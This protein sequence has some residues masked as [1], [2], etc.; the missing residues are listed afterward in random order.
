[1]APDFASAFV[2]DPVVR[3]L[4]SAVVRQFM[5]SAVAGPNGAV[6]EFVRARIALLHYR[7][8]PMDW[9]LTSIDGRIISLAELHGRVVLI[10]FW[11]PTCPWCLRAFPGLKGVYDRYHRRGL[12]VIGIAMEEPAQRGQVDTVI[13]RY[14]LPWPEVFSPLDWEMVSRNEYS[15]RYG[16]AG[17]PDVLVIDRRG[18]LVTNGE[19]GPTALNALVPRLLEDSR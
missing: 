5:D 9:R 1:L 14:A 17:V 8:T 3:L 19:L 12:E 15:R 11:A 18:R 6:R 13:A 10:Q 16:I 2:E 7:S 4:D